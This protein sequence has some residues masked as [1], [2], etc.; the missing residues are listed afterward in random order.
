MADIN[1]LIVLSNQKVE[2]EAMMEGIKA[3]DR[4]SQPLTNIGGYCVVEYLGH[5]AFGVVYKVGD[6]LR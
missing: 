6:I 2:Q 1:Y 5:G 4:S 3:L